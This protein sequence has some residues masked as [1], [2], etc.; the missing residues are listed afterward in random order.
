MHVMLLLRAVHDIS[1]FSGA[2]SGFLRA[3]ANDAISLQLDMRRY[4]AAENT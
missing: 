2:T 3:R 1:S 4:A